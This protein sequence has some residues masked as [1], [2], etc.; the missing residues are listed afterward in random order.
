MASF[1]NVPPPPAGENED[2]LYLN[3]YAP[4]APGTGRTVMFWIYGGNLQFG[5]NSVS[6]YDGTAFAAE[7]GVVLVVPNYR[8]NGNIHKTDANNKLDADRCNSFRISNGTTAA[9]DR[10]QSGVS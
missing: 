9:I 5:S 10:T 7:Q 3:V 2:C 4:A 1:G 8:T 6:F